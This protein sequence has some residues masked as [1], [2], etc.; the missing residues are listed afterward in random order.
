MVR[1]ALPFLSLLAVLAMVPAQAQL[2]AE[3]KLFDPPLDTLLVKLPASPQTP[4]LTPQIS[5]FYYPTFMVKQVDLG[6]KGAESHSVV[7]AFGDKP[8]CEREQDGEIILQDWR[9][10]FLG[11]KGN[12]VFLDADDGFNGGL[13]FAVFSATDKTGAKLFEDARAEFEAVE[14][15]AQGLSL[16]LTRVLSADCSVLADK[17][18]WTKVQAV[19]GL[20]EDR[21]PDCKPA[22][23]RDA[24]NFPDVPSVIAYP[25]DMRFL[26]R[27]L[28]QIARPG[29]V[30]CYPAS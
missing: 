14:L 2:Q 3:A 30:V 10:Y 15:D 29:D 27:T 16:R 7:S 24:P 20:P 4:G 17:N 6:E 11:V 13:P 28:R 12:Y 22:Y 19:T 18:C 5:C 23:D 1:A 8:P 9:G 26:D 21:K 25:A